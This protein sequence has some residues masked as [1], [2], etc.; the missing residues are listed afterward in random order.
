M[1]MNI[2]LDPRLAAA[3]KEESHRTGSSQQ[4]IVR[5]AIES[6]L[7]ERALRSDR[8]RAIDGGAVTA[9]APYR[10]VSGMVAMPADFSIEDALARVRTGPV[11]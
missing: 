8:Q 1:A 6:L 9:G 10:R 3:L 2:R 5:T 7:S 11:R 4:K